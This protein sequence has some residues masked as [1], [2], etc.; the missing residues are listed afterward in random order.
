MHYF[1]TPQLCAC[2]SDVNELL[3]P[4]S[5]KTVIT[6]EANFATLVNLVCITYMSKVC[7][8]L[9]CRDALNFTEN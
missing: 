5:V 2:V 4:S 8:V 7:C 3:F 1:D 9:L 6:N